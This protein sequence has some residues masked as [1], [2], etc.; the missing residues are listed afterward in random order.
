[1]GWAVVHST[2]PSVPFQWQSW[3]ADAL[4]ACVCLVHLPRHNKAPGTGPASG[5]VSNM[6]Q[7]I[8]ILLGSRARWGRARWDP[9]ATEGLWADR[10]HG[11]ISV[12]DKP[13]F[14]AVAGER[15]HAAR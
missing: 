1:M 13:P 4:R 11:Q 3:E 15:F 6:E 9:G 12:S 5:A 7:R 8:R 10:R 14:G 2:G